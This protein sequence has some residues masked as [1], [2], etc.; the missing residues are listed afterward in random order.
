MKHIWGFGSFQIR[1]SDVIVQMINSI[2]SMYYKREYKPNSNIYRDIFQ[3]KAKYRPYFNI[4]FDLLTNDDI[5]KFQDII[6]ILNNYQNDGMYIYCNFS[7]TNEDNTQFS[8]VL[9]QFEVQDI[10]SVIGQHVTMK[11][12]GKYADAQMITYLS[13]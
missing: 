5:Y 3:T 9:D 2:C 6:S 13:E 4:E 1:N 8:V 10:S 11:F 7:N 12:I